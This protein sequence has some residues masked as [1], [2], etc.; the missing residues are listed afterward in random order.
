MSKK[1]LTT[2]REAADHKD[3]FDDWKIYKAAADYI[4]KL[5]HALEIALGY[6]PEHGRHYLRPDITQIEEELN[7]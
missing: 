3:F 2:L 7:D 6:V 4:E 5:E 1:L